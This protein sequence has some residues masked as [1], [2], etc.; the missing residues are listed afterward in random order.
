MPL[1]N[2]QLP[3]SVYDSSEVE[4]K[5][6]EVKSE[7]KKDIEKLITIMVGVVIFIVVTFLIEIW[8]MNYDRIKDKDIYLQYTQMYKDYFD[9]S[10]KL[11][12]IINEQKFNVNNL[13]NNIN[14]LKIKNPYL[15]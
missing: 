11:K 1:N 9:E 7:N 13:G 14:L 4:K 8:S 3:N 2:P 12:E 15:K 10:S 5:I 6:A